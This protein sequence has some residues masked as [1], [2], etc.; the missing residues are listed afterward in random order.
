MF[1]SDR[2]L[3]WAVDEGQLIYGEG[4]TLPEGVLD[5]TSIDLSL[6]SADDARIWDVDAVET[7]MGCHG[8]D[9]IVRLGKFDYRDFEGRYLKEPPSKA[10]KNE[11][12]KVYRDGDMII[13]KPF[14]FVLWNIEERVGTPQ[15]WPSFI[16]FV[17]GKSTKARTGLLVH[18]TAP[19][20]H[21]GWNG[22]VVLE[23]ANLGPFTFGLEGGDCIAQLTVATISS[24]PRKKGYESRQTEDQRT[25][26]EKDTSSTER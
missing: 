8:N 4:R 21:A 9:G 16:C 19:T 1:L 13:V 18:F 12:D 15:T 2:D 24:H 22:N 7:T 6:A 25:F 10:E 17:N 26:S 23:I 11:T 14:G 20:I 5:Q 3:E